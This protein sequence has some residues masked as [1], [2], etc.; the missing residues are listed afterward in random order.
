[1]DMLRRFF[2]ASWLLLLELFLDVLEWSPLAKIFSLSSVMLIMM[3]RQYIARAFIG[4]IRT[5]ARI[6]Y[7]N[8]GLLPTFG[9]LVLL[10]FF[11]VLISTL[12][13]PP[14]PSHLLTRP[15]CEPGD[16]ENFSFR[17]RECELQAVQVGAL[18]YDEDQRRQRRR[19]NVSLA[20]E[21]FR[22]CLVDRGLL[23]L[24]C[25]RGDEECRLLRQY[26]RGIALPSFVVR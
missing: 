20:T 25:E 17:V 11:I 15:M 24:A 7:D 22:E 19:G 5:I 8:T 12:E 18:A 14:L 13:S 10:V 23:W 2:S 16:C 9:L 4:T 26:P 6:I 21:H 3:F 1:M